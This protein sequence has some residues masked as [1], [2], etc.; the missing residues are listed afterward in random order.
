MKLPAE[1]CRALLNLAFEVE[2]DGL[3]KLS[4]STSS[5]SSKYFKAASSCK[6]FLR[7]LILPDIIGCPCDQ[8]T[9][10][11]SVGLFKG[12]MHNPA[13][14]VLPQV[15]SAAFRADIAEN[16]EFIFR[17]N[18]S[19]YMRSYSSWLALSQEKQPHGYNLGD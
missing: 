3:P 19:C 5:V 2:T 16:A 9:G 14:T 12:K 10:A 11:E 4:Q 15:I 13:E 6:T 1:H 7:L 17:N 8:R 18:F